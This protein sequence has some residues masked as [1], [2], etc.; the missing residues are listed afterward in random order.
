[1]PAGYDT[2]TA[3]NCGYTYHADVLAVCIVGQ[4]YELTG[5]EIKNTYF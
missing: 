3:Q 4:L 2:F 5:L 1:M